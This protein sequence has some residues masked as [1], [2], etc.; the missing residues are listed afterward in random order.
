MQGRKSAREA[1]NILSFH[2]ARK[3]SKKTRL[4]SKG[5]GSQTEVVPAGQL[6]TLSFNKSK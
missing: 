3:L 6:V 2:I 1:W 4:I 5:L